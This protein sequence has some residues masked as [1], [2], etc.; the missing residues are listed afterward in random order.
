MRNRNFE[1]GIPCRNKNSEEKMKMT[2]TI[3]GIENLSPDRREHLK[4][5]L[6]KIMPFCDPRN[7]PHFQY[8]PEIKDSPLVSVIVPVYN[9]ERY[10]IQLLDSL[11]HQ[12]LSDIEIICVDDS[13][14]DSSRDILQFYAA[15]DCRVILLSQPNLGG[16]AARNCGMKQARGKYY[17][18]MDADD[19][20]SP[21]MLLKLSDTA[22]KDHA[23]IVVSKRCDYHTRN[24]KYI[25]DYPFSAELL[26]LPSPFAGA[27]YPDHLYYYCRSAPW[28][29]LF[30]VEFIRS[31]N[32]S[33]QEIRNSNDM[34]FNLMSLSLAQR[35]S[36]MDQAFYFYRIGMKNNTQ[37]LKYKNPLL[38]L[39]AMNQIKKELTE[40]EL[41]HRYEKSFK[42]ILCMEF[43]YII[44]YL[45]NLQTSNPQLSKIFAL[46]FQ[47]A[48]ELF[49]E[50]FFRNFPPEACMEKIAWKTVY[51]FRS[52]DS[53]AGFLLNKYQQLH[54]YCYELENSRSYRIGRIIARVPRM[55]R[56]AVNF[57][58]LHK[59]H[60]QSE[61]RP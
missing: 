6:H 49:N 57:R 55:L 34:Y 7:P 40:K 23:E 11:V 4:E 21:D 33:F 24:G 60:Q 42:E 18:F 44:P 28:G 22:E 46:I 53:P 52:F 41:F 50:E 16:G 35:I 51:E 27:D 8:R 56:D 58:I 32:L 45:L 38:F 3:D 19:F 61:S 25:E 13:S 14:T 10:L 2:H 36:I 43:Y 20:C 47:T 30:S 12:T 39:D 26:N 17:A 31:N 54:Q 48:K 59:H 1:A 15:L 37:A 9:A 29:K 5:L